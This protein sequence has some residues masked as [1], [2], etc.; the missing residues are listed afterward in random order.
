[1]P[2]R[3]LHL[4]HQAVTQLRPV[5]IP[6]W[7]RTAEQGEKT[8]LGSRLLKVSRQFEGGPATRAIASNDVRAFWLE[9]AYL[10]CEV[11]GKIFNA[12]KWLALAVEP[13]RLQTEKRL[14]VTQML[15][16]SAITEHV[17]VVPGDGENGRELAVRL[18][19]Y[20]GPL[21]AGERAG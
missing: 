15:C 5:P 17:A 4:T 20:D 2:G 18:Q 13:G 12:S 6:G 3:A 16:Q 1:M 21:L 9:V 7:K 11:R 8:E 10:T 19:R 14:I